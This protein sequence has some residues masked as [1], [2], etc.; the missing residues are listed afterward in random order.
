MQFAMVFLG[1]LKAAGSVIS[2]MEESQNLKQVQRTN[3]LNARYAR[4]DATNELRIATADAEQQR[5]AGRKAV[6][7]QTAAFAQSG[8]GISDSAVDAITQS[9]TEAELDALQIQYKGSLRNRAG[10]IEAQ[11]YDAQA[12]AARRA[13][14]TVGIKTAINAGVNLLSG[15]S[16]KLGMKVA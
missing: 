16:G 14:K 1:G 3:E 4:Q 10:Q 13:R 15:Y 7:E 6:G 8:F 9:A 5:R 11:G 12:D 2:G